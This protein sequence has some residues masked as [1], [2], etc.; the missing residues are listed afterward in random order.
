MALVEALG[1][2]AHRRHLIRP[3]SAG[4]GDEAA[5]LRR[6]RRRRDRPRD[7]AV[8]KPA[9]RRGRPSRPAAAH[10]CDD[11]APRAK[12][13]SFRSGRLRVG[14]PADVIRFDP[15]EPYVLDPA[16]LHSRCRNTPFDAA[17]LEG[18]VKL[19]LVAGRV[20]HE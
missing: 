2:G 19:T 3:R 6:G 14:A 11:A 7:D 9:P 4:R 12:S 17:R 15:D 10:P 1:V 20:A 16:E 5:A 8:G 13:S 18:R